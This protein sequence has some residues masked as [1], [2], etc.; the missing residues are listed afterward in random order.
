MSSWPFINATYSFGRFSTLISAP[1]S[2]KSAFVSALCVSQ[3]GL[4]IGQTF[5]RE[6]LYP[7]LYL[8]LVCFELIRQARE[9]RNHRPVIVFFYLSLSP[10]VP[11]DEPDPARF[12]SAHLS[13]SIRTTK[14]EPPCFRGHD[15]TYFLSYLEYRYFPCQSSWRFFNLLES[16]EENVLVFYDVCS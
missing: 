6:I 8:V 12:A 7:A 3:V 11:V 14:Y 15:P 1:T 2:A 5:W 10:C 9:P 16:G 13:S 4:G